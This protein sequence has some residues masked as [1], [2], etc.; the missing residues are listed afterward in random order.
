MWTREWSTSLRLVCLCQICGSCM[1]NL[2]LILWLETFASFTLRWQLIVCRRRW[3]FTI[4]RILVVLAKPKIYVEDNWIMW[5]THSYIYGQE[6]YAEKAFNTFSLNLKL[7]RPFF[8]CMNFKCKE[9][10]N[11][12]NRS[13]FNHIYLIY[14]SWQSFTMLLLYWMQLSNWIFNSCICKRRYTFF[15]WPSDIISQ[16]K[17]LIAPEFLVN[18]SKLPPQ[19]QDILLGIVAK[20]FFNFSILYLEMFFTCII[21]CDI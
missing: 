2:V 19:H 5:F 20:V 9:I 3:V 18:I 16:E 4:G 13:K 1:W 15:T 17:Q 14:K 7:Q 11:G 8:I 12:G 21:D 6:T 10:V